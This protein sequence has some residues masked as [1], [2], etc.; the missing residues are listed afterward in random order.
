MEGEIEKKFFLLPRAAFRE[1]PSPFF[2]GVP[3]GTSCA[4]CPVLAAAVASVPARG[5][6][7]GRSAPALAKEIGPCPR[8]L[9]APFLSS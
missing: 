1:G 5:L 7:E 8:G 4:Y 3:L 6:G 2:A 9:P